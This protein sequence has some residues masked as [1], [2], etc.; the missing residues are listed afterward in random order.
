M[1]ACCYTFRRPAYS[2]RA[3]DASIRRDQPALEF[4]KFVRRCRNL[5]R[6]SSVRFIAVAPL[7][8]LSGATSPHWNF[9]NSRGAAETCSAG[10]RCVYRL[11]PVRYS[12]IPKENSDCICNRCFYV[13][14]YN[15]SVS[16]RYPT[17]HTVRIS[18]PLPGLHS[19]ARMRLMWL[20]TARVS[21][22]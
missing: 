9:L 20:S 16:K 7:M 11:R 3:T 4:L 5:L 1:S 6:R 21:P 10:F 18:Q 22:R 12:C 17:P 15:T 14:F 19:F 2:S 13:A 8:L